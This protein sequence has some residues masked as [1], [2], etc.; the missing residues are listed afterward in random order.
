MAAKYSII[1]SEEILLPQIIE[2]INSDLIKD[3]CALEEFKFQKGADKL[4]EF[5]NYNGLSKDEIS[6][7][8][9]RFVD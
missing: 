5:E 8:L 9:K 7:L 6:T 1:I 2:A 4:I 3:L